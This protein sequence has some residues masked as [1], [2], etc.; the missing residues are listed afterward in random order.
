MTALDE[1]YARLAEVETRCGG[2]RIL[3]ECSG[4][5][6]W[7]R[8]GVYFFFE[9]AED[10]RAGLSSRV[11]RVG[12]H[13]LRPSRST[14]WGRLSQHQ[15]SVGGARPGGGNHRASIFRLHVGACLAASRRFEGPV[16]STWGLGSNASPEVREAEYRLELA[17]SRHIRA[18]PFV[19]LGVDDEP[20]PASDRGIIERGAIAVLSNRLD[21]EDPPS[22]SWLGHWSDRSAVRRSGLWNVN[23]TVGPPGRGFLETMSRWLS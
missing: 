23:H 17:V 4:R 14:L 22:A 11:V 6:G 5:D 12:T 18:M 9:P 3:G 8:R 19:W 13:G 2:R 16:P 15:G 7:P 21:P 1:F 20:G 10:R